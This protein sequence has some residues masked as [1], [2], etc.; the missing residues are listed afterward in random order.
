[1]IRIKMNQ[2]R[3]FVIPNCRIFVPIFFKFKIIFA[4]II[5]ENYVASRVFAFTFCCAMPQR[6]PVGDIQLNFDVVEYVEVAHTVIIWY[7]VHDGYLWIHPSAVINILPGYGNISTTI[8]TPDRGVFPINVSHFCCLVEVD[9]GWLN[10]KVCKIFCVGP[11]WVFD[12][13]Q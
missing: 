10:S 4:L 11:E 6:S 13:Y 1:M 9:Y 7:C 12:T 2:V 5:F 8:Q 3:I